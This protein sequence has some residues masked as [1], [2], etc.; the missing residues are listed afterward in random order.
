MKVIFVCLSFRYFECSAFHNE[1]IEEIFEAAVNASFKDKNTKKGCEISWKKSRKELSFIMR[2]RKSENLQDSWTHAEDS[3]DKFNNDHISNSHSL[4]V[5][6]CIND[7]I[8]N[9]EIY[10]QNKIYSLIT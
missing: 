6:R 8:L 3:I 4:T 7:Y 1:G 10:Y 5:N 2:D 9:K